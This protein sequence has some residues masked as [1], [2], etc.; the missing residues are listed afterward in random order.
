MP[1]P[2][3]FYYYPTAF[4]MNGYGAAAAAA[5]VMAASPSPLVRYRAAG[6]AGYMPGQEM[7]DYQNVYNGVRAL[8]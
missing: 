5:G 3:L 6:A 1:P 4:P 8:L 2:G 7:M